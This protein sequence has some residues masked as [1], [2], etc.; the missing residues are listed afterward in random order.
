MI[1]HCKICQRSSGSAISTIAIFPRDSLNVEGEL[2]AY[3]YAGDS[4]RKLEINFCPNCGAPV[5]L[6]IR[7][8]PDLVS[9]K[10][11]SLDDTSWFDPGMDIWTDSAQSWFPM[12][13][14]RKRF[15]ANP[16]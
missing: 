15:P 3:E 13:G 9:I 10:V 14:D 11:G 6:N 16:S 2:R 4:A 8:M 1:C 7:A 5:L 12:T